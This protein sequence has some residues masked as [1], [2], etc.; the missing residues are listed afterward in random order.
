MDHEAHHRVAQQE[1]KLEA[2]AARIEVLED[3]LVALADEPS[4]SSNVRQA[5]ARARARI[6]EGR[7]T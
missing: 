1:R 4:L 7:Q 5:L 2:D 6:L 3:A